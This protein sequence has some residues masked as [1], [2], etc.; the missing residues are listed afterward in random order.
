MP[1]NA[2]KIGASGTVDLKAD[3]FNTDWNEHLV[4]HVVR[5]ELLWRRQGT[6]AVKGRGEVS[7]SG[8]KPHKQKGTG[9]PQVG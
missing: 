6:H 7:G 9:R 8:A 5:N 4:W 2:P 1:T 3:A